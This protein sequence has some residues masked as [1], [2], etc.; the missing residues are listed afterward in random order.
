MDTEFKGG[1]WNFLWN[2][3][4][5]YLQVFAEPTSMHFFL[6]KPFE[7]TS[8][9]NRSEEGIKVSIVKHTC[10]RTQLLISNAFRLFTSL[11]KI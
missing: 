1:Q 3:L 5:L 2:S 11:Q 6:F 7:V 10:V 4:C 9:E 8:G